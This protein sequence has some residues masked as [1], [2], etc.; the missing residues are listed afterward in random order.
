MSHQIILRLRAIADLEETVA[1]YEAQ[2]PGLGSEF[3]EGFHKTIQSL[4]A[5]PEQ[6]SL[7]YRGFRRTL[8]RRFPYKV[9]FRI[10]GEKV[11]VFRVLHAK[12][13]HRQQLKP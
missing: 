6:F 5:N 4:K 8:L 12:R 11:I 13:D 3:I 9:F 10:E 2:R 7:Y 1:W